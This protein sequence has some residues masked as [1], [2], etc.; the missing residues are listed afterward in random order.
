MG[1]RTWLRKEYALMKDDNGLDIATIKLNKLENKFVWKGKAYNIKRNDVW[2]F[3]TRGMLVHKIY[4]FYN[5]NNP[6]PMSFN[7]N[8]KNFEPIISPD[9]YNRMLENEILIKLNTL[10][11]PP[12]N[13]KMVLIIAGIA[14]AAYL[15]YQ[16]G[17]SPH[18]IDSN[19]V[20]NMT[21]NISTN[22]TKIVGNSTGY[23]V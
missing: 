14:V 12:I 4:Y 16:Y 15:F 5:I 1:L 6:N 10:S 21:Q 9:L 11:K 8:S 19:N 18:T 23:K 7:K 22:F 20:T 13:W 2:N 3:K 17:L